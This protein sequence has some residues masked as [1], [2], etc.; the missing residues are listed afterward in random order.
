MENSNIEIRNKY[1]TLILLT[2]QLNSSFRPQRSGEPESRKGH[3]ITGFPPLPSL[4]R[5]FAG[6][7]IKQLISVRYS[8]HHT[9]KPVPAEAGSGYPDAKMTFYEIVK[10]AN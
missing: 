5:L 4:G 7:T 10:I 1:E 6:M 8:S 3:A 2:W 9:R